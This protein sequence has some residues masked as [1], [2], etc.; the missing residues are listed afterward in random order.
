M[1]AAALEHASSSPDA[2]VRAGA[3]LSPRA[4]ARVIQTAQ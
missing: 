2:K 4:L 1:A 3:M